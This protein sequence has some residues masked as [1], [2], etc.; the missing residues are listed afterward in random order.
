M[1]GRL[2]AASIRTPALLAATFTAPVAAPNASSAAASSGSDRAR[3]GRM[4]ATQISTADAVATSP[5][6]SRAHSAPASC[7]LASAPIETHSSARP[8]VVCEAPTWVVTSGMRAAQLPN[9]AP[10]KVKRAATA[11]NSL[12][13]DGGA[14][15]RTRRGRS[16]RTDMVYLGRETVVCTPSGTSSTILGIDTEVRCWRR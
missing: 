14:P 16:R 7:M 12:A 2:P 8:S 13:R 5:A 4:T 15:R 9:T 11:A 1:I 3:P 6:P 10:S